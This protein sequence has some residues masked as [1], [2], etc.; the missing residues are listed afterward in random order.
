ME[1]P[2]ITLTTDFGLSDHYVGTMKGV[3]LSR[4][5]QAQ[6]VDISHEIPPFSIYAGA[7]AIDQAAP[8]FPLGTVHVVVV[9]P[10]VGTARKPLYLSAMGQHFVAPDNGVLSFVV[11]RDK[12][13]RTREI[14]NRELFLP[15]ASATF[16]GR[17]VF[18][19]AAAAIAAGVIAPEHVG[20]RLAKIVQ[21]TGLEPRLTGKG[22]WDGT[23]L[24]VDRF[25]NVVTNFRTANFVLTLGDKFILRTAAGDIT[26]FRS[27]FGEAPHDECFAYP[28]SSGYIEIG[29]NQGSAARRLSLAAGDILS[30]NVSN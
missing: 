18:A 30:L 27:T 26:A 11:E 16:H 8:Y 14:T 1:R 7:Y 9:D 13:A 20:P 4:N 22:L 5:P 24:S 25:G 2:I 17:D 19:P 23:V 15:D 21:L 6:L 28:G 12:G 3:I 10:G 29:I